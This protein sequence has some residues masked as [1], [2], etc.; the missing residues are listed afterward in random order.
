MTAHDAPREPVRFLVFAGS[1][2]SN[3]IN[4]RLAA[5]MEASGADVDHASM[6]EF[7]V[8]S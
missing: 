8:P 4:G 7:A 2:R 5:L 3:S 1:L 6:H